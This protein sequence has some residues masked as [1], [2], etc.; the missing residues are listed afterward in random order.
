MIANTE[1]A[2]LHFAR[3]TQHDIC[4][5]EISE[6]MNILNLLD[7]AVQQDIYSP[8]LKRNWRSNADI[9]RQFTK[10]IAK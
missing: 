4:K 7:S 10:F 1:E 3:K 9:T 8:T 2:R 5:I 6:H